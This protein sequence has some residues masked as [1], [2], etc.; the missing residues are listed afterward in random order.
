[1]SYH[2]NQK[3]NFSNIEFY[4]INKNDT[5]IRTVFCRNKKFIYQTPYKLCDPSTYE[6][7]FN[8][9][10]PFFNDY[11]NQYKDYKIHGSFI[12]NSIFK[13][14]LF[15]SKDRKPIDFHYGKIELDKANKN[16]II[17]EY[18]NSN[19][20]ENNEDKI[21]SFLANIEIELYNHNKFFQYDGEK[22]PR[23]EDVCIICHKN[24][25]NVL[26]TKCFHLVACSDCLRFNSLCCCPFCN[27]PYDNFHKVTFL[28]SK[29]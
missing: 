1:M 23:I 26:I 24:K 8:H 5:T 22:D 16:K 7:I 6:E 28:V 13:L 2:K 21:L 11:V 20:L 14:I 29:K 25:P 9:L 19:L 15:Y 18:K 10:I 17:Y 12:T 3:H 27:K 4:H